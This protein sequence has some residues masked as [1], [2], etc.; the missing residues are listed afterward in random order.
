M[1]VE[2]QTDVQR[3]A[4]AITMGNNGVT[5]TVTH[6]LIDQHGHALTPDSVNCEIV[7]YPDED[8]ANPCILTVGNRIFSNPEDGTYQIEVRANMVNPG[9]DSWT[10]VLQI[11]SI[12]Y[13]SIQTHDHT[14]G[15]PAV[16]AGTQI[17]DCG[18]PN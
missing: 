3:I 13:H 18:L 15:N 7:L 14:V 4:S 6:N 2:N 16:Q 10:F 11:T 9:P 8:P 12:Y 5:L 17:H 1:A